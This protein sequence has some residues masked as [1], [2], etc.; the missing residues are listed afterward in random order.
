MKVVDYGM[1]EVV[2]SISVSHPVKEK[3][4]GEEFLRGIQLF[5]ALYQFDLKVSDSIKHE[6]NIQTYSANYLEMNIYKNMPKN[7]S[8]GAA[9]EKQVFQ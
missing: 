1:Y 4:G 9:R 3:M 7:S 8:A 6:F 2:E 5:D